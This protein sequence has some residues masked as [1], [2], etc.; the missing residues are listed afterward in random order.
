MFFTQISQSYSHFLQRILPCI[1]DLFND[2][3]APILLPAIRQF[4]ELR[5]YAALHTQ[6]SETIR[7][8]E[9]SLARFAISIKV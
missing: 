7:K 2:D 6:T 8:G 3:V 4:M 1:H 5:M 9:E